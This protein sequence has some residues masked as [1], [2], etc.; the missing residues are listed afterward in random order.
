MSLFQDHRGQAV[1]PMPFTTAPR[2]CSPVVASSRSGPSR[3][4]SCGLLQREQQFSFALIFSI[5]AIEDK[6]RK[7][8]P[9]RRVQTPLPFCWFPCMPF[10]LDPGRGKGA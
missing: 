10:S 5:P 2:C 8:L 4:D 7:P 1:S 6:Q 3:Q 9:P